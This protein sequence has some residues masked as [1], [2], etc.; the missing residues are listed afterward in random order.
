MVP[1]RI[2][3]LTSNTDFQYVL[4]CLIKT[5]MARPQIKVSHISVFFFQ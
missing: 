3:S 4:L 1:L 5:N 2:P